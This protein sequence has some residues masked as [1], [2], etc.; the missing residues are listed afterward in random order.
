MRVGVDLRVLDDPNG[1]G[2]ARYALLMLEELK[3]NFQST[4]HSLIGFR[5]GLNKSVGKHLSEEKILRFSNT[6]LNVGFV[7]I[8]WPSAQSCYP[9]AEILWQPNPL[10]I[11][12]HKAPLF[13]T[14]HDVSF[15][16]L[17]ETYP[18]HTRFWYLSYVRHFLQKAQP[19]TYLL[20]VSEHT[21][22]D[23]LEL[24]PQWRG[25]VF[26]LTPPPCHETMKSAGSVSVSE[27][28]FVYLGT[29]EIRKNVEAVLNAFSVFRKRHSE[30]RLK[31]IGRS[32]Y[33]GIGR[34][35]LD[36]YKGVD[37][38][39]Y[40]NESERIRLLQS[41]SGLIY[42][43]FYEGYGYPPIEAMQ[44][45]VPVI[46]AAATSLPE[47]L[48]DAASWVNPYRLADEL[49]TLLSVISDDKE[50]RQRMISSGYACV[51]RRK[52]EFSILKLIA[53]WENYV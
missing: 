42:P 44:Y 1:S 31:I 21:K 16:R 20:A 27:P 13:V 12:H 49:P 14:I 23:V 17:P 6:L 40:V 28:Y 3:K 52:R 34:K 37:F 39:G 33:L 8:G 53:L 45:G 46:G 7:T 50:Y 29:V 36:G 47:T 22:D 51:E 43:S 26:V 9:K 32:G 18:L 10:F 41:S 38:L 4:N 48:G 5:S 19:S 30:Y 15:L 35:K 11:G 25:R 2:V 24:F